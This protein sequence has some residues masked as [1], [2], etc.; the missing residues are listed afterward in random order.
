MRE[1]TPALW[2]SVTVGLL[3]GCSANQA[4]QGASIPPMTYAA[5]PGATPMPLPPIGPR[6]SGWLSPDA[7]KARSSGAVLYATDKFD[8]EILIYP[9]SRFNQSPIGMISSGVV[10]PWA[11]YVDKNGNLYVANQNGGSG[12]GSVT[13]Y[14]PGSVYPSAT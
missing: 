1:F 8:S 9:E 6:A 10:S 13:V 12:S 3:T 2:L 5:T 11:L 4:S 7:R 14:P